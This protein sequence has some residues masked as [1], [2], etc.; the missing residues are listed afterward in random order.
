MSNN[1]MDSIKSFYFSLEDKYYSL[2]DKL[3]EKIPVYKVI[4]PIDKVVPSFLV[5]ICLLLLLFLGG[6]MLIFSFLGS[7]N[8]ANFVVVSDS[9]NPLEAVEVDLIFED[10][11]SETV[12][13][14]VFGEFSLAVNS[15]K[16]LVEI[17][18]GDYD[19]YS[20]E[21]EVDFENINEVVLSKKRAV[22]KEKVLE[23]K[24][25]DGSAL[26]GTSIRFSC[27]GNGAPP[28]TIR[29]AGSTE[30]VM[31]SE[32]CGI[33]S[34]VVTLVGY[35]EARR[36][37][38]GPKTIIFMDAQT[39]IF[40]N[41]KGSLKVTV[42]DADS[43]DELSGV[44]VNL[45]KGNSSK[46]KGQTDSLGKY[47]FEVEPGDYFVRAKDLSTPVGY[48]D[49][50]SAI[51]QVDVD[52]VK[53]ITIELTKIELSEIM[54]IIVQ[55]VDADTEEGIE[56]AQVQFFK[57]GVLDET[58]LSDEEGKAVYYNASADSEY[59]LVVTSE[60]Y[61]LKTVL[62][63]P[64]ISVS[65]SE[66]EVIE[67]TK[68]EPPESFSNILV[69][70]KSYQGN[71]I[72]DAE[73]RLYVDDLDF[74]LSTGIT[75]SE[76]QI[77]FENL[78][79]G[80]Y[81]VEAE[82]QGQSG[83]TE[84]ADL[85]SA[86]TLSL[87]V[88]L[89]LEE[90]DMQVDVVDKSNNPIS[91]A[92]VEFRDAIKGKLKEE[93]TDV[94]GETEKVS[95]L[96]DNNPY[97]IVS[98]EGYIVAETVSYSLAASGTV[99]VKVVL[100]TEED[101]SGLR[102]DSGHDFCIG[103]DEIVSKSSRSAISKFDD[104]KHYT[105]LMDVYTKAELDS[106][107]AVVRT[108]LESN[109]TA[110]D[111]II[112]IK[113]IR[114]S[115]AAVVT[116]SDYDLS[117]N[118]AESAITGAD[119]KQ[120]ILSFNSLSAGMH[121][122]E[123]DVYV[124]A[125]AAGVKEE[126]VQI[127]I[128][129]GMKVVDDGD[130]SYLPVNSSELFLKGAFI[131]GEA[132]FCDPSEGDCPNFVFDVILRNTSEG[133]VGEEISLDSE[134]I[135][136]LIINQ[137]YEL[138]VTI[139]NKHFNEEDFENVE[140]MLTTADA[141]IEVVP[142]SII[143]S[144]LS[145]NSSYDLS[146]NL[147]PKLSVI[148]TELNIKLDITEADNEANYKFSVSAEKE[149]EISTSPSSIRENS[150]TTLQV[151][152]EEKGTTNLVS[153]ATVTWWNS[154]TAD[155]FV[156]DYGGSFHES[157]PGVYIVTIPAHEAGESIYLV[158][159]KS[160]YAMPDVYKVD[161]SSEPISFSDLWQFECVEVNDST[162]ALI[163]GES[164]LEDVVHGSSKNIFKI[165]NKCD[166][167]VQ[168]GLYVPFASL[169][170]PTEF[171]GGPITLKD[172]ENTLL[173]N[174]CTTP[175]CSGLKT[176]ATGA[177]LE[178][179]ALGDK[180][181]GVY[182]VEIF[183]K[184]LSEVNFHPFKTI[185]VLIKPN[186]SENFVIDKAIFDFLTSD[187]SAKITNKNFV[188]LKDFWKPK[189]D[190]VD[191]DT[192]YSAQ[193]ERYANI[194]LIEF[195][196]ELR[197]RGVDNRTTYL[198]AEDA[199]LCSG[200]GSCNRTKKFDLKPIDEL[201]KIVLKD[202]WFSPGS[203]GRININDGNFIYSIGETCDATYK[204]EF[205]TPNLEIPLHKFTNSFDLNI[206]S[207]TATACDPEESAFIGAN[208]AIYRGSTEVNEL[209]Y[210]GSYQIL[211]AK[212]EIYELGEV[213]VD[214]LAALQDIDPFFD[215]IRYEVTNNSVDGL[216]ETWV[217]PSAGGNLSVKARFAQT[218]IDGSE[219]I[220]FKVVKNGLIG[221]EFA[222]LKVTDYVSAEA[223]PDFQ[224]IT[225][226]YTATVAN[227]DYTNTVTK[228]D[229]V[230]ANGEEKDLGKISE[231]ISPEGE[232]SDFV[233]T[234]AEDDD[235]VNIY[236]RGAY[237][238]PRFTTTDPESHVFVST[239]Y[240]LIA[241]KDIDLAI[242]ID[243]S[244][245]MNDEWVT[246]CDEKTNIYNT[247]EEHGF[248][249]EMTVFGMER[250]KGGCTDVIVD[251]GDF[252]S[253]EE[254]D[255]LIFNALT[256]LLP[257]GGGLVGGILRFISSALSGADSI[258]EAWGI[259]G[260][261]I[262]N[263]KM[264]WRDDA[265]KILIVIGDN[266]P[267][268]QGRW[269]N[270]VEGEVDGVEVQIDGEHAIAVDL[271][272]AAK[273]KEISVFFFHP[274]SMEAGSVDK[275]TST[276][277]FDE[278]KNDAIELMDF[279][280]NQ[281]NG[282]V[283]IYGGDVDV[284]N[285]NRLVLMI[286]R[287]SHP[288]TSGYFHVKLS[289]GE[290]NVC[291]GSNGKIGTT[292]VNAVPRVLPSWDWDKIGL[293]TCNPYQFEDGSENRFVYCD[294]TQFTTEI[295][296][297][298]IKYR[299]DSQAGTR[300]DAGK[301]FNFNAYLMA[302]KLSDDFKSDFKDYI[303][304]E[305]SNVF[306]LGPEQKIWNSIFPNNIEF[307]GIAEEATPVTGLYSV[308]IALD[309]VDSEDHG[310]FFVDNDTRPNVRVT[311][312]LTLEQ[313]SVI[314]NVLYS[315]PID[316]LVGLNEDGILDREGYGVGFTGGN[317]GSLGLYDVGDSGT[318]QISGSSGTSS[319]FI[320][321]VSLEKD[322]SLL[323]L[324]NNSRGN[325]LSIER[326]TVG[327][328]KFKFTPSLPNPIIL[329][330]KTNNGVSSEDVASYLVLTDPTG[331]HVMGLPYVA[332]WT[333]FASDIESCGSINL[334][335]N[336]NEVRL[337]DFVD[338]QDV[339]ISAS[340]DNCNLE[341]DVTTAYGFSFNELMPNYVALKSIIYTPEESYSVKN[342]CSS[343]EQIDQ[344]DY[345][346]LTALNDELIGSDKVN[347]AASVPKVGSLTTLFELVESEYVCVSKP[348]NDFE[349]MGQKTEFWWNAEKIFDDHAQANPPYICNDLDL[350]IIPDA[351]ASS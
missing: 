192:K 205:E 120:V 237:G 35:D 280:A 159:E 273:E 350:C 259:T 209:I 161:V 63:L 186:G 23:I 255:S 25:R 207:V 92:K 240:N 301:L 73:V 177:S 40:S 234:L 328:V 149:I 85:S 36:T 193:Q 303:L 276:T 226:S 278:T 265:R 281:T 150:S 262:I 305:G 214:S 110:I 267:S 34:A 139:T 191:D 348:I 233:Y 239:G 3:N 75:D 82:A 137:T 136:E 13:T 321:G 249:V 118:Y 174:Q 144:D 197:A 51:L 290:E 246:M 295:I 329:K 271:V 53:E 181:L 291:L 235:Y 175:A 189:V 166:T 140:L 69:T 310:I 238:A 104:A 335:V 268:G 312:N 168:I 332:T 215:S 284:G 7:S 4:D 241:T 206:I 48:S 121:H 318:M 162:G 187:T 170:D 330:S 218:D 195:D 232:G 141:S 311:V 300:I 319:P 323:T 324:N 46:G 77:V 109:L 343:T 58:V 296:K 6:L 117:D 10:G 256:L 2:M 70:V 347:L 279:V 342:A 32:S 124:K 266:D 317:F 19:D 72:E 222:L 340:I 47:T 289:A 349:Q 135:Q 94:D 287:S 16:V 163:E 221:S 217:E 80:S 220:P 62:D 190:F 107:K 327:A 164:A 247:L 283:D 55:F 64:L 103:I 68:A 134:E 97:L 84:Y 196:W 322:I 57:D 224:E 33:L 24:K 179:K 183:I 87:E 178:V 250:A 304:S 128:R 101:Y 165:I 307:T 264:T 106:V 27:S 180:L 146:V 211:H 45:F 113:E 60:S 108:G 171:L 91:G 74:I 102:C 95:F 227:D 81:K 252:D 130:T 228:E 83:E 194:S 299:T 345:F 320:E 127:E 282:K 314:S 188:D 216:I 138:D 337:F 242:V 132:I 302:D 65:S 41:L 44:E 263:N 185:S 184:N 231:I 9:G 336:G 79:F 11:S 169:T 105:L 326:D 199:I 86:A 17:S 260:I 43:G 114:S 93:L 111:S 37:L 147:I 313:E 258:D 12:T 8:I 115:E 78:P 208:I 99:K 129:Y 229:S 154:I 21:I 261:N 254:T 29:N 333:A 119:G 71:E 230:P 122:F 225:F 100:R 248:N 308:N 1:I 88:L 66:A 172:E 298:L 143:L 151:T 126:D 49:S 341:N 293:D 251:A 236:F 89:V 346:R 286:L 98:H 219:D 351:C 26:S 292:G 325:L 297:R 167:S 76:G 116:F 15:A 30:R 148:E 210:T 61:I 173:G 157:A 275:L 176:L 257:N 96:M 28:S 223:V 31:V 288:A 274:V 331:S 18:F 155:G 20:D 272:N 315:L 153:E 198:T 338:A 131:L 212:D 152:L 201:E 38:S 56:N 270:E 59:S 202:V 142:A 145:H 253:R 5:L 112:I 334:N 182:D 285:V 203:S 245:S 54:Q 309:W 344:S 339:K 156:G 52:D 123:V 277:G 306:Q 244:G 42:V 316:G 133:H 14:D 90:G 67:L 160:G 158:A 213:P 243:T 22:V 39:I 50:E 125:L 200:E 204:K 294:S 269:R